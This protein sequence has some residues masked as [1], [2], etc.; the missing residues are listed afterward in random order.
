[1]SNQQQLQACAWKCPWKGTRMCAQCL[2]N[3]Q[4]LA[5]GRVTLGVLYGLKHLY[6]PHSLPPCIKGTVVD[7]SEPKVSEEIT[8]VA[9]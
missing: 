1:M 5:D 4:A 2:L 7:W 8:A 6:Q 3:S 9:A